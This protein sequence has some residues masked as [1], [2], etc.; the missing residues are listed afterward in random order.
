MSKTDVDRAARER[1]EAKDTLEQHL[2][3]C[4]ACKKAMKEHA[5]ALYELCTLGQKAFFRARAK[6]DYMKR[7]QGECR[8]FP[9][10][11]T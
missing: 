2:L 4:D 11:G 9:G 5:M 7:L 10:D 1:K 3:S 8:L 6:Q